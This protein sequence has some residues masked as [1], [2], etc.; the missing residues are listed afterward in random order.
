M[1]LH[2]I[3]KLTICWLGLIGFASGSEP[4]AIPIRDKGAV[5]SH[6]A[7]FLGHPDSVSSS[8]SVLVHS[9]ASAAILDRLSTMP[10]TDSVT[11]L[12]E[13]ILTI[14]IV[15][16][17][18][19]IDSSA[20]T[21]E[22]LESFGPRDVRV[23]VGEE[24]GDILMIEVF[25]T[26]TTYSFL[27]EPP[28]DD[29]ERRLSTGFLRFA[30]KPPQ[31]TLSDA[32]NQS[33]GV[34]VAF[35]EEIRAQ[36]YWIADDMAENGERLIWSIIGKGVPPLRGGFPDLWRTPADK[37]IDERVHSVVDAITGHC[38]S[39]GSAPVPVVPTEGD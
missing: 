3:G 30:E 7:S 18:F 34:H 10:F 28:R 39:A 33:L 13:R 16:Y 24:T 12:N 9:I 4:G 25:R 11:R 5:L 21:A 36:C 17:L 32:F 38:V 15:D 6:V 23:T 27:E 2:R 8:T 37:E 1:I 35:A 26:D 20:H 14:E 22:A 31:I 29:A 19:Q